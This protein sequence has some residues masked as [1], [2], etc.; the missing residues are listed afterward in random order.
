MIKNLIIVFFILISATG[1]SQTFLKS[2]LSIGDKYS[3][4]SNNLQEPIDLYIGLP[5]NY[6]QSNCR[7]PVH[8]V[9]DGQ[10]IFSYYYGVTDMLT[11]GEI[12]ECI[13]VGVQSVKR[14]YYFKP[15]NGANEFTNFLTKELIPF[16]DSTY[17][18]NNLR[19][20]LG[21]STTGAFI[22]NTLLNSPDSFDIYIAGAPYHSDLFLK[23]GID[24]AL[25][26]FKTRKHFYSFYGLNDNQKEKSNWDSLATILKQT[27][28]ENIEIVNEEYK[29]EGHYSIIYRYIP[30]GL[31]TAFKDWGYSPAHGE[32]FSYHDFIDFSNNQQDRYN[33]IFDYSEGYFTGNSMSLVRQGDSETAIKLITYGLNKYS[34]SDVLHSIIATEYEKSGQNTLAIEHYKKILEIK[35]D[36]DFIKKKLE[37]LE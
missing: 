26:D 13:V 34:K 30:D 7:Y 27:K 29:D 33:V 32:K 14:G 18:T 3:F 19:L 31:K 2:D 4:N 37:D 8:Y 23:I 15:G 1:Y 17:R 21:H 10:I 20:I 6:H 28:V 24:S 16:I 25:H 12:P 11:K 9:L 22:V 35:P 5:K 36:L